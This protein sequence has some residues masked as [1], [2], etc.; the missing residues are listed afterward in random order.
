[1]SFD[2]QVACNRVAELGR[3]EPTDAARTE[4]EAA[5]RSKWEGLQV[6]AA[7]AL[8]A[9]GDRRSVTL[10]QDLLA[11]LA[12]KQAGLASAGA[13][14]DALA[15]HLTEA[16]IGWAIDLYGHAK[17]KNKVALVGLFQRLP[18]RPTL[19]ALAACEARGGHDPKWIRYATEYVRRIRR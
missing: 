12:K 10:V 14:A 19:A 18:V 6:T 9:W 13:V 2:L 3:R 11:H 5:L 4:V 15:P 7:K 1:M 16:D 17:R 8:S